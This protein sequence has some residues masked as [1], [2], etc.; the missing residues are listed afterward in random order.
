MKCLKKWNLRKQCEDNRQSSTEVHEGSQAEIQYILLEIK[1]M[2]QGL[3]EDGVS[4]ETARMILPYVLKL[5]FI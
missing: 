1:R 4:R 2:Y 5:K 3:I